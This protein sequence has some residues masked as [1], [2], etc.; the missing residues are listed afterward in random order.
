MRIIFPLSPY[1]CVLWRKVSRW[2]PI[3]WTSNTNVFILYDKQSMFIVF[4]SLYSFEGLLSGRFMFFILD[5][6][7]LQ[8]RRFLIYYSSIILYIN[9]RTSIIINKLNLFTDVSNKYHADNTY[10]FQT[11]DV[12]AYVVFIYYIR[13]SLLLLIIMDTPVKGAVDKILN[14][15]W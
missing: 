13:N 8:A 11:R 3:A 2:S 6:S 9:P 10:L 5:A 12:T 15:K 4:Y 7:S 14:L 1:S